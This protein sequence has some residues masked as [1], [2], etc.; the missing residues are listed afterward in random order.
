MKKKLL[1]ISI[2]VC[3]F[4]TIYSQESISDS[5]FGYLGQAKPGNTPKIFKL[6]TSSG[7]FAAERI[8]IS[9]NGK[10]IYYSELKGYYP[11]SSA[12]VKYYNFSDGVW[13]GPKILFENFYSPGLSVDGTKMYFQSVKDNANKIWYSVKSDSGWGVPSIF[14][15]NQPLQYLLQETNNG[16]YYFSSTNSNGG[17]G[18]RDWSR[19][20]IKGADTILQSLGLPVNTTG[21]DIDFCVSKDESYLIMAKANFGICISYHKPD[22]SWTNPKKLITSSGWNP[23]LTSDNK[24][25]FYTSGSGVASQ[26][27]TWIYWVRV[28]N[29]IENLKH[30]NFAPYMKNPIKDQI[31][32]LRQSFNF[33]IPDSTFIDDDGN[34]ILTYSAKLTNGN[35]LPTWL[36]FDPN[37]RTFSG[38]PTEANT[39]TIKVTATDTAKATIS[40]TFKLEVNSPASIIRQA[41]EKNIQIYPNPTKGYVNIS[42]GEISFKKAIAEIT[43]IEGKAIIS[44]NFKN[45]TTTTIDL[46]GIQKGIYFIKLTIDGKIINKKFCLE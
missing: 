7:F 41:F 42:F 34:N 15:P 25:L 21:D 31:D 33:I 38:T 36:N 2:A 13:N 40:T 6:P 22:G 26:N 10:E 35:L 20:I 43:N 4:T 39:I 18:L 9:N 16:N 3:L 37:T 8:T 17:L 14:L 44:Y 23:C 29:L 27:N 45:A 11:I 30:T 32:T 28:D 1:S 46:S 12:R 5:S 19:L 24:Y